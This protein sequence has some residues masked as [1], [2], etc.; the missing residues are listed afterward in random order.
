VSRPCS[1]HG[2]MRTSILPGNGGEESGDV[3]RCWHCA[4]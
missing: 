2:R 1:P 3:P 4:L